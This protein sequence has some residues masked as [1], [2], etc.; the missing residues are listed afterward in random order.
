MADQL[1]SPDWAAVLVRA[2]RDDDHSPARKRWNKWWDVALKYGG[3]NGTA[4]QGLVNV[5]FWFVVMPV[6]LV[7][8]AAWEALRR[9]V[10]LKGLG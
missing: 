6:V 5:T 9:L 4:F 2:E 8:V 1:G 10:S 7:V 3:S